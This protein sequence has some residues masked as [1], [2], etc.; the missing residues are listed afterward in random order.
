MYLTDTD[1]DTSVSHFEKLTNMETLE[2]FLLNMKDVRH[3]KPTT[4][5]EKLRR[6]KLA[7]QFMMR[8]KDDQ[9]YQKGRR[10][11]DSI[12]EWSSGLS[13]DIAV[14]RQQHALEMRRKLEQIEDPNEFL[15][16]EE[17]KSTTCVAFVI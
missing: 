11:L 1:T 3:Y 13:R 14:Q 17:V 10:V 15:E 7:I 4:R 5:A 9:Q 12:S 6:I 8:G 2:S 16:N